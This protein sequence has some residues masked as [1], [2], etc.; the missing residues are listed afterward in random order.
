MPTVETL[1][2]RLKEISSHDG[3]RLNANLMPDDLLRRVMVQSPRRH[4]DAPPPEPDPSLESDLQAELE[5]QQQ[6]INF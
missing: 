6:L 2:R 4:R 5:R 3:L 1:E